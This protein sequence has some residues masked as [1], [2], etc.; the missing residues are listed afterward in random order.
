M[1]EREFDA[2]KFDLMEISQV[3]DFNTDYFA[4]FEGNIHSISG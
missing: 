2:G 4:L 3:D 1:R